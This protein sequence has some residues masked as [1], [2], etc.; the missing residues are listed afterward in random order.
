MK[1]LK[2]HTMRLLFNKKKNWYVKLKYENITYK[3]C[4]SNKLY[5]LSLLHF[6]APLFKN[7]FGN[8]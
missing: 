2:S 4:P 6:N 3:Y 8:I 5:Y 1:Y 7:R